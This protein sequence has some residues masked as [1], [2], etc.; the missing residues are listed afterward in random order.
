MLVRGVGGAGV[1][2][3]TG[4]RRLGT[5]ASPRV[6]LIGQR[7][8][9]NENLGLGYLRA[10]LRDAG[11][12]SI[13]YYVNDGQELGVAAAKILQ[14]QPAVLGF[15]LPDGGS[16]FLGLTLGELVRRRGY[17]GHITCGGQFA[18]LGRDWLLSRY[19]WLDSVVRHDG[20]GPL[21]EIVR[22]VEA[23]ASVF[24]VGGVTTREG[25]GPPAD[26][27]D[28]RA[29]TI[30]PE[31][32]ELPEVIGMPAAHIVGS[33]GCWGRCHYCG[34]A[35]LNTLTRSEGKARGLGVEVL[36]AAGVGG[37]RRRD[38]KGLAAKIAHLYRER[39][40][41]YF[42]FVDEHLLPQKEGAA[43]DY[44]ARLEEALA[45]HRLGPFGIGCMLRANWITPAIV[46]ALSRIGLVRCFVGLEVAT[47]EEGRRYGRG[48][49]GDKEIELL[50]TFADESIATVSNLLMLHPD[51][52]PER[53]LAGTDLLARGAGGGLRGDAHDGL[54]RHQVARA[55]R[56]RGPPRQPHPLWLHVRGPD[57]GALR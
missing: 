47:R 51:S 56:R 14:H 48:A 26:V 53:I 12:S 34:P 42:Y 35:A 50:K 55:H 13:T 46:R 37:T 32:D 28:D 3:E 38:L 27:L 1:S 5:A 21:V 18:T 49:P 10:S 43:L 54:P 17:R 7:L 41:R 9:S 33:R 8:T 6:V 24:G 30:W 44:L 36:N 4:G 57:D 11:I 31:L 29:M 22:H 16:S 19:D 20:E 2:L 45:V 25:E 23:G 15:S 40:V 39:G 52:T